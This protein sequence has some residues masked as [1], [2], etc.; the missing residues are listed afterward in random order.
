MNQW[1]R[2]NSAEANSYMKQ[3][4]ELDA[5]LGYAWY[6]SGINYYEQAIREN[7]GQFDKAIECYLKSISIVPNHVEAYFS[8]GHCYKKAESVI[9]S[10]SIHY[11]K[12]YEVL[13]M[14]LSQISSRQPLERRLGTL[15]ILFLIHQMKSLMLLRIQALIFWLPQT[16]T[17]LTDDK[18][19][20]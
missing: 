2:K 8:L 7:T 16:I 5:R 10:Y 12:L 19:G 4:L 6:C 11:T 3:V 14:S 18:K 1:K 9:T 15:V 13:R 20:Y 17:V